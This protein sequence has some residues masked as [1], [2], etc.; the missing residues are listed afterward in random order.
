[1]KRLH[2]IV[3]GLLLGLTLSACSGALGGAAPTL[4]GTSWV[5]TTIKG[6]A[7]IADHQPTLRFTASEVSG[8]GGCNQFAGGYT[9]TGAGVSFSPVAMT[10][11]ACSPDAVMTQETDFSNALALVAKLTGTSESV[12]LMDA[13]GQVVLTL[14]TAASASPEPTT[15]LTTT[16]WELTA[17]RNKDTVAS[18][19]AGSSVTL[20]MGQNEK[21]YQGKACNTF[22]GDLSINGA[23][24]TFGAPRSTKMA[25]PSDKLTGQESTVLGLIVKT[26][27]WSITG[28]QLSLS[29]ADGSGLDFVAK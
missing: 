9:Q 4:S 1:M 22:G 20:T 23:T 16:V 21:S 17:I 5:V 12:D 19:V 7:T 8:S 18:P 26:E 10:A 24:I 29:T 2:V 6:T 15:S 28:T 14:A 25:C 27:T 3:A 11:M 13:S